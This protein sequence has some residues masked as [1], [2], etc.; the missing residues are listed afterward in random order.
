MERC[1][2]CG[3]GRKLVDTLIAGPPNVYICNECVD[4]CNTIIGEEQRRKQRTTPSKGQSLPTP[5][6]IKEKLDLYVVGQEQTKKVLAVAVYNHYKRIYNAP[7]KEDKNK[8]EVD[9]QKSNILLIG[10]TGTGKTLLAQTLANILDVPF[11]IGDAT[12]LTEAGYVGEDVESLLLRLIQAADF[13]LAR[14]GKGIIFIDEI[15]KIA[16]SYNNVSITRDVSGEGVQQGLLKMLEGT[17]SNI[18]P[19]GGRKHP[20]QAFIQLDTTHILFIGGGAFVGLEETI[21][22]RIGRKMIGFDK[23]AAGLNDEIKGDILS[24]VEPEDMIRF[25]MIPEF[26][27]RFPII[28]ALKPLSED[29]LVRILT[30]PKNAIIRQYQKLFELENIALNFP[31]TALHEI[32]KKALVRN[33]G[34]RGLRAILESLMLDVMY[35][36]PSRPDVKDVT[37]QDTMVRGEEPILPT[38]LQPASTATGNIAVR[39]ASGDSKTQTGS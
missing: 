6:E 30:E 26:V 19:H 29:N 8:P 28:S 21:G 37:I 33:T 5:R 13:D 34:A 10:P 1:T 35:E 39:K 25:G 17:I 4:L 14:A 32:A 22:K 27:G 15:D 24:Q 31:L 23:E 38:Q 7:E 9:I 11:A 3:K 36:L 20:E 16:K 12:T 2:F 18:P